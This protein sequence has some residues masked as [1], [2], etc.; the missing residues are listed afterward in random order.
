M[1]EDILTKE[2]EAELLVK[3][4]EGKWEKLNN[5][6]VQHHGYEFKYGRNQIDKDD[7]QGE[8]PHFFK[9]LL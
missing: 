1:V 4:D 8:I 2:E 5:R 7:R 3:I 6:R 9:P